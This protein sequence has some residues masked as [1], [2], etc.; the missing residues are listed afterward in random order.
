MDERQEEDERE[1]AVDCLCS[2]A[3]CDESTARK[4]LGIADWNFETAS[5][6]LYK[7]RAKVRPERCG[8]LRTLPTGSSNLP[9]SVRTSIDRCRT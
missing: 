1:Q 3:N 6:A 4:F 7:D 9:A 5:W 2:F 8:S